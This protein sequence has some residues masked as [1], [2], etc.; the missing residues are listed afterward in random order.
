MLNI[1]L[2]QGLVKDDSLRVEIDNNMLDKI[3]TDSNATRKWKRLNSFPINFV[4]KNYANL[5]PFVTYIKSGN[6]KSHSRVKIPKTFT[7]DLAYLL[8]AMR[9]GSL[10]NVSRKHWVRLY[11]S[12]ESQWIENVSP[13]FQRI[14]DVT[15][16]MRYQ[17]KIKE[18]YLD[19]SSKPLFSMI[20]LLVDGGLQKDVPKIIKKSNMQIKLA[21]IS[22]FFDA[23]GHVPSSN[24]RHKRC[25]VTFTQKNEASLKFI[26]K[27]LGELKV[28][29]S[30][31]SNYS[32]AIYGEEMVRKF[33]LNVDLL[34]PEKS[35]RLRLLLNEHSSLKKL[36]RG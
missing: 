35:N 17:K 31:I 7:P 18:K 36:P 32:F 4:D 15:L 24:V 27:V 8:G 20:N 6:G 14:F 5:M 21:Y 26:K 9:D 16:H 2:L 28:K 12:T 13:L 25:R 30:K 29:T 34:N 3:T 23:E 19:I 1:K 22:G 11:D 33:Y 10:I